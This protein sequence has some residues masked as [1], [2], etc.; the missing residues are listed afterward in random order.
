[1]RQIAKQLLDREKDKFLSTLINL[2]ESIMVISLPEE[3]QGTRMDKGEVNM[4]DKNECWGE[5]KLKG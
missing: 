3:C 5:G 4:F 2:K 1:M